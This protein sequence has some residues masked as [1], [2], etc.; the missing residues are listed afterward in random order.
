[1]ALGWWEVR[2]TETG[3]LEG[4]VVEEVNMTRFVG[5]NVERMRFARWGVNARGGW[6]LIERV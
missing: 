4:T 3:I 1:M 5:C 2:S 6:C